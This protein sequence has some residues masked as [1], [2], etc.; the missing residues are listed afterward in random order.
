MASR[1]GSAECF[2]SAKTLLPIPIA[3]PLVREALI[4][5][6]L[7]PAVRA[8]DFVTSQGDRSPDRGAGREGDVRDAILQRG[9]IMLISETTRELLDF[10]ELVPTRDIDAMALV[11]LEHQ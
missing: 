4:Q 1:D 3:A 6:S 8:I 5:F 9:A 11:L 2:E 7:D 10:P